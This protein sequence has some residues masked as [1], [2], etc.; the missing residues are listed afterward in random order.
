MLF[1]IRKG[2]RDC[3][4][5]VQ[6]N[7]S[8]EAREQFAIWVLCCLNKF[9]SPKRGCDRNNKM[10]ALSWNPTGYPVKIFRRRNMTTD[11]NQLTA[12]IIE[13]DGG[14]DNISSV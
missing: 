14:V 2:Q 7:P 10:L 1:V 4:D 6:Q 8:G 9:L 12:T 11:I 13:K 3:N 5:S